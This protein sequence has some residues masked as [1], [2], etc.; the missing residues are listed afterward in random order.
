MESDILNNRDFLPEIS[1]SASRSSG[2]GGQH[3]NKVSTKMELR[4]R[5]MDSILLT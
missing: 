2:P 1:F 5:V 3:V 4:F